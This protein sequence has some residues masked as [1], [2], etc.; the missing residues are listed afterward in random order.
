[1]QSSLQDDGS[2]SIKIG[3]LLIQVGA[4]TSGD[5]TEAIQI[6]K[7]MGVPIG[8]VLVMSG[9]VN[10]ASLKT[11]LEVQSLIRDGLVDMETGIKALTKVFKEN[12]QL[13]DALKSLNW[14]PK[15]DTA[16]NK[17]GE[18][19]VDSDIVSQQQLEK[20]LETSFQ[21][22]MPLGGTLV[23]QGVISAQLLPTVL[24]IQEQIRD[25]KLGR[26]EA[27]S[28]LRTAVM[29][30][31]RAEHSKADTLQGGSVFDSIADASPQAS[32]PEAQPAATL[33]PPQSFANSAGSGSIGFP[34]KPPDAT[35]G[36]TAAAPL[37]ESP[38][39]PPAPQPAS[40][41]QTVSLSEL[42]KLSGF[43]TQQMLDEAIVKATADT[44]LYASLLKSVGFFDEKTMKN[45][46]LCH[47]LIVKGVLRADQ[48]IYVLNSVRH[49]GIELDAALQE[50]GIMARQ[51]PNG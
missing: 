45:Y 29:F 13:D 25:R 4:L 40:G 35:G 3:E 41:V 21:S 28:Q 46:L 49:R 31:A 7:R 32:A 18:L 33:E 1:M 36:N 39:P 23:L 19:L 16:G 20:A 22:G 50:I 48:A 15:R 12:A 43:C 44:N 30:W 24:Y 14:V 27:V 42:L 34:R 37:A 47:S 51:S 9:C 26:D 11:T 8:R 2:N 38:T 10:E 6:S 17:L 5:L